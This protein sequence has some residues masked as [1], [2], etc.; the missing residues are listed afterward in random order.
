MIEV[1][2]AISNPRFSVFAKTMTVA[3]GD[4]A[5]GAEA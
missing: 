4:I 2:C 5:E 3:K 1:R